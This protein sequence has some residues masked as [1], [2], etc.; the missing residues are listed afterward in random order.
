LELEVLPLLLTSGRFPVQPVIV[1]CSRDLKH[2]T[3]CR[4]REGLL[5]ADELV[6]AHEP[7][8]AKKAVAFFRMSRSIVRR[9]FSRRRRA[10]SSRSAVVRASG[11]PPW[12]STPA[13]FTQARTADSVRSR[14]RATSTMLSLWHRR[15]TSALNSAVNLRRGL[16][17]FFD[18]AMDHS[19]RILAPF[20]VSV[21]WGEAQRPVVRFHG[22]TKR[23]FS[24]RLANKH[25]PV[26][27]KYSTLARLRSR[28]TKRNTSPSST[29]RR[30]FCSTSAA[31]VSKLLR[32]SHGS[33]YAKTCTPRGT[34]ITPASSRARQPHSGSHL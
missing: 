30:S 1:G 14:R 28:L 21:K 19:R 7:S 3:Q 11:V 2:S 26:P 23:P 27:S 33:A 5:R 22:A 9:L 10:S 18:D 4:H 15:T 8:F 20:G 31:S 6:A 12:E 29:S 25:K 34:P 24:R 17:C 13:C 32:M 16:R